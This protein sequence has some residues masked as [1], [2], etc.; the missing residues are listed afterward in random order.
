MKDEDFYL[1]FLLSPGI[2]PKRLR[3]L[4]RLF[5]TAEKAWNGLSRL[6]QIK[7]DDLKF[8]IYDLGIGEKTL[9]KFREFQNSYDSAK[10][11]KKLE[12]AKTKFI[13]QIDK[14]Y[15]E[16][17]KK[18][19]DPPI[20]LFVKGNVSCLKLDKTI[21]VVGTRKITSYGRTVT[22]SL[23]SS[24]VSYRFTIVSGLAL[25][26]DAVSHKTALDNNGLTIV[27]LGCGVDCCYPRENQRLYNSILENNGT[28]VSEYPLEAQ[29]SKGTFPAR[30]R[31]IAAISQAILVTEAGSDSGSLITADIA[32]KLGKT[33]FAV[34]GPITSR[35]SDGTSYMIK[36]GSVLVQ[37]ADDI[38]EALSFNTGTSSKKTQAKVNINSLNLSQ[39][40]KDIV[41]ILLLEPTHA[42]NIA[43]E[44][45]V[46]ASEISQVLSGLEIQ[47]TI[48]NLGNNMFEIVHQKA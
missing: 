2:G 42:D 45:K 48:R 12:L 19:E 35:Q 1:A 25:G 34:P 29:P 47:G 18:L 37:S 40:E 22:E 27:V 13:S 21:G 24:L 46:S 23:V 33:V 15:P 6:D 9:E 31:I 32:K 17:L 44:L 39:E 5:G 8:K 36:N 3:E 11:K 20:G 7:Q 26:V 16:S 10:Y 41:K 28:I 38:I 30:N 43:K 14:E 4:I